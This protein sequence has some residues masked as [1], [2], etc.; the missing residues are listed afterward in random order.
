MARV[1]SPRPLNVSVDMTSA[2][3]HSDAGT[4]RAVSSLWTASDFVD[5]AC[6]SPAKWALW[7][8]A[9]I[10]PPLA[11]VDCE[12]STALGFGG[13]APNALPA[14]ARAEARAPAPGM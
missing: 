3:K 5:T 11:I 6:S 2:V 7:G 1:C 12:P 9:Q 14:P 13:R 4:G 10:A 8:N